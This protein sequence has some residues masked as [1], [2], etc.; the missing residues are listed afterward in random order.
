MQVS[1][2]MFMKNHK[3]VNIYSSKFVEFK[4]IKAMHKYVKP[5]LVCFTYLGTFST[6]E[7]KWFWIKG[8]YE[9][10]L[11]HQLLFNIYGEL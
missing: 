2:I 10:R 7:A 11:A 1:E 8:M 5:K 4:K 9:W 6:Q 3:P